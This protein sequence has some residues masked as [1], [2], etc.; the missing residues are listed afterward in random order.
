MRRSS[1]SG[2][3]STGR[4]GAC[5]RRRGPIPGTRAAQRTRSG[6][7]RDRGS[8][9]DQKNTILAIVLS[10]VVL[11]VWQYFVGMPQMEKQ[12]QETQ[13]KQ[14]QQQAQQQ[15]QPPAPGQA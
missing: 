6:T 11:I 9:N 4:C 15:A 14:Q 13:L 2:T 10:A 8:M 1:G 5:I 7:R 3:N 12:R